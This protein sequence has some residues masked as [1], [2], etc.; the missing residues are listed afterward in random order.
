MDIILYFK[1][2]LPLSLPTPLITFLKTNENIR[3][4]EVKCITMSVEFLHVKGYT[5]LSIR[6]P[7]RLRL[8]FHLLSRC[9]FVVLQAKLP[10]VSAYN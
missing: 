9:A 2:P 4:A 1:N 5:L 8:P 10:K 6:L 3:H 7:L